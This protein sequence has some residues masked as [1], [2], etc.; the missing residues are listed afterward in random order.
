[1]ISSMNRK[2]S[3]KK[4]SVRISQEF[5]CIIEGAEAYDLVCPVSSVTG[6]RENPLALLKSL[7]S[8]PTKSRALDMILQE[9]PS[10]SS[11]KGLSN[12]AL[13]EQ[14][15]SVLVGSTFYEDDKFADRLMAISSDLLKTVGVNEPIKKVEPATEPAPAAE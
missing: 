1:M 12:D 9:L 11:P 13:F 6:C 10:L 2:S 3:T 15:Q 7:I 8:D 4:L 5:P 14:L